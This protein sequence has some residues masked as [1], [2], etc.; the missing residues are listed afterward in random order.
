MLI[1]DVG[2]VYGLMDYL[3]DY[4]NKDKKAV[5]DYGWFDTREDFVEYIEPAYTTISVEELQSIVD[6]VV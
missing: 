6:E 2:G 5:K 4:H 3:Q 1:E